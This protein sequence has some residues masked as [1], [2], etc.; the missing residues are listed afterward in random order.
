MSFSGYKV[1]NGSM[2]GLTNLQKQAILIME[3]ERMRWSKRNKAIPAIVR[4]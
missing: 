3:N 2:S 4:G 1:N